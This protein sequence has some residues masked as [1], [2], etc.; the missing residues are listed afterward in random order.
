MS[1]EDAAAVLAFWFD[2][3]TPEQRFAKDAA[4]DA[5]IRRR[6]GGLHAALSQQVPD[7]WT[8]DPRA[9]LAAVIVLDQ[10]SRN[11]YRDD[12]RAFARDAVALDLARRAIERGDDR[13]MDPV[14]RQ[15]LYMPF[16]HSEHA[17]D[18]ARCVALMRM[19]GNAEAID[20]AEQ[21][22]AIIDRFGRFPHRNEVLGR[23]T[24]AEEAE[25]LEQPGSSF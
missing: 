16:M 21:H 8:A 23:T 18:Q 24:T 15:F 3:L 9:L 1:I 19:T 17:G 13:R 5:T 11:L 14:E 2:E 25:F 6:F 12:P 7:A 10:F 4:I 22:R 20:F